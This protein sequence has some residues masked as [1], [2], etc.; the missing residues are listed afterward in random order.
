MRSEVTSRSNFYRQKVAKDETGHEMKRNS[1]AEIALII[2]HAL[3]K[4]IE[5]YL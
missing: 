1:K 3:P 2:S 5:T 4:E